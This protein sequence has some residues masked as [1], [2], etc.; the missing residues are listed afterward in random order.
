M[1]DCLSPERLKTVREKKGIS[2]AEAARK[3][4]MSKIG[5]CRYE[6]GDRTPSLQTVEVLAQFY[7]TS[8]DYLLGKT[9]DMSPDCIVIRKNSS[10]DLFEIVQSLSSVNCSSKKAILEYYKAM[11][12]KIEAE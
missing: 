10:P 1:S 12:K 8:V 7:E 6:Y 3:L 4:N 9:D 5:Y 11:I 2:M